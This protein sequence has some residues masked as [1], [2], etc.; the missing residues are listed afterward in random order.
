M[1]ITSVGGS[2]QSIAAVSSMTIG[3][4]NMIILN[5]PHLPLG[6]YEEKIQGPCG[7]A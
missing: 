5:N 4:N 7:E 1:S 2:L 6:D 3:D